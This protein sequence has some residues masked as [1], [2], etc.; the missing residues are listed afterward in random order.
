M[1]RLDFNIC[2]NFPS[3]NKQYR[4]AFSCK[5]LDLHFRDSLVRGSIT[6]IQKIIFFVSIYENLIN[7]TLY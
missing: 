6:F 3:Q 7:D 2:L 4:A 1:E 5:K